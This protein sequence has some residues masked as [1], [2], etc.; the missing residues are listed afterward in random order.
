MKRRLIKIALL[1]GVFAGFGS[2]AFSAARH[3]HHGH[4][5]GHCHRGPAVQADSLQP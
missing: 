2:A 3:H 1:F 4:H 5:M